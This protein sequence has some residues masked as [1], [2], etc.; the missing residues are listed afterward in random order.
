M[1]ESG[2]KERER[3]GEGGK[4]GTVRGREEGWKKGTRKSR[5]EGEGE[6]GRVYT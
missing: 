3:V 5:R 6:G 2:K 4:D 1:R